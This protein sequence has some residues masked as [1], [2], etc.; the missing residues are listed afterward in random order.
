[1]RINVL[2]ATGELGARIAGHIL[3]QGAAPR[4]LIA[5]A[6]TPAKAQAL[7]DRGVEVRK[8][9]YDR[10]QTLAAALGETDTLMLIPS[11]ADVE[12]RIAQFANA[13][14]AARAAGVRRIVMTSFSAVTPESAFLMAPYYLYAESRLRL[15]GLR[16]TILRNG[17]YLD[18]LADWAPALAATGRL[19]Y[20]V[21]HGRIA[22]ISRDDLARAS[23]AAVLDDSHSHAVY[24]LTGPEAVSMPELADAL[25]TATGRPI[26]FDCV[27]EEEF[28]AVCRADGLSDSVASI[29][30]S[31]YRAAD[32]GEFER[33]SDHVER[34]TGSPASTVADFLRDAVQPDA[35]GG[36]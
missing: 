12:P 19:P 14:T 7:A 1:M 22:Y 36:N 4:D 35:G 13:L 28:E 31:M 18:P 21:K 27:T 33:V 29:L 20:P 5:S 8:A 9:D 30:T 24:E 2:G 3:R 26:A 10:P 32:R 16:W 23:A 6:R 15:S 25:S 11:M 34:L 17:M